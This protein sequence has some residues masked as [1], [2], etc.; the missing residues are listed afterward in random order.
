MLS[1]GKEP[2]PVCLIINDN[3][4]YMANDELKD[5]VQRMLER[6][7]SSVLIDVLE[8][9]REARLKADNGEIDF[10]EVKMPQKKGEDPANQED[11][12]RLDDIFG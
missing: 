11:W 2:I 10:T 3:P 6:V 5:Q 1:G 4:S 12:G 7:P 8:Y 9:L